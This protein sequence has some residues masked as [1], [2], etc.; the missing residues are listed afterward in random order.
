MGAASSLA[1]GILG[2]SLFSTAVKA[3][4]LISSGINLA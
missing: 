2:S 4:P 3:L 1:T